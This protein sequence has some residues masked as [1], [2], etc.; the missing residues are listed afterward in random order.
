MVRAL[1]TARD[2]A[3]SR[4]GHCATRRS[5]NPCPLHEPPATHA[6]RRPEMSGDRIQHRARCRAQRRV[7][8]RGA[9]PTVAPDRYDAALQPPPTPSVPTPPHH[10]AV[11]SPRTPAQAPHRRAGG[12]DTPTRTHDSAQSD[13]SRASVTSARACPRKDRV[14]LTRTR[15]TARRSGEA[16]RVTRAN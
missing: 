2:R 15:G 3:R 7:E 5:T 11:S 14:R 13:T 12:G 1:P 6:S 8:V 16:S 4:W 10:G 9:R